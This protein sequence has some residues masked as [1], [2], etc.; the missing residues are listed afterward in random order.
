MRTKWLS[1]G[2]S[3]SPTFRYRICV[4]KGPEGDNRVA[5]LTFTN[6]NRIQE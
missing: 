3:K 4:S 2:Y 5:L 1:I 6:H